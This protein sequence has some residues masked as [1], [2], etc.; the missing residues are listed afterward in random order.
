MRIRAPRDAKPG[1]RFTVE[2]VQRN[3]K[4]E[5]LGGFDIQVNIVDK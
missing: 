5:L 1:D 4:G 2:V 3:R